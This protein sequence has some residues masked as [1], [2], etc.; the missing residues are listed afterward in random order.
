L[1][2]AR[3][4]GNFGKSFEEREKNHTQGKKDTGDT[5]KRKNTRRTKKRRP[6]NGRRC[7][8]G[9]RRGPMEGPN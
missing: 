8:W 9:E 4:R 3:K 2:R 5:Q 7:F 1:Y 6:M